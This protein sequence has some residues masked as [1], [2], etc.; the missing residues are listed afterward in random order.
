[1]LPAMPSGEWLSVRNQV[2]RAEGLADALRRHGVA[3]GFARAIAEGVVNSTRRSDGLA[4]TV[5]LAPIDGDAIES[6]NS[7]W[8]PRRDGGVGG[9]DWD[10]LMRRQRRFVARLDVAVW[11]GNSLCGLAIGRLSGGRETVRIDYVE[12]CPVNHPLKGHIIPIV[13]QL[14]VTTAQMFEARSVRFHRPLPGAIPIYRRLGFGLVA[15][16]KGGKQV[17]LHCERIL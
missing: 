17:P 7:T 10:D 1:M 8:I 15:E 11:S 2:G 6:W 9:W 14:A 5:R 3:R 16:T 12:G 13:A 4:G